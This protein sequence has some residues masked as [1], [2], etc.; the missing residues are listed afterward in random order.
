MELCK[1]SRFSIA[2]TNKLLTLI[3]PFHNN[4]IMRTITETTA[5][6]Y[7]EMY[8]LAV[9]VLTLAITCKKTTCSFN[10]EIIETT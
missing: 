10:R 9:Q 2:D 8:P 1:E 5:S 6:C 4:G 3:P 7:E